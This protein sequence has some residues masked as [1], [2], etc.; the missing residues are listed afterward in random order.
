MDF[1][2]LIVWCILMLPLIFSPGPANIATASVSSSRGFRGAVPFI[3]GIS[4]INCIMTVAMGVGMGLIYVKYYSL[5]NILE[6][7]GALYIIY[8]GIVII[9]SKPRSRDEEEME[10]EGLG[11]REGVTMQVLNTKLYP[12]LAMM[13][14]QFID[15][16]TSTAGELTVLTVILVSVSFI[17]YLLWASIGVALSRRK[18]ATA[19]WIERYG[20]GLTLSSIGVWL[21]FH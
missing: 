1:E 17:N 10:G 5:F 20:F 14:S 13:F 19:R 7:L 16:D 9:R 8:L 6:H 11:F 18:G 21:L 2:E 4:L 15:G 12:V 3:L